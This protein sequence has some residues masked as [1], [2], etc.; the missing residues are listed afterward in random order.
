M[1]GYREEGEVFAIK[2]SDGERTYL[3]MPQQVV[4][5]TGMAMPPMDHRTSKA[6]FQHGSSFVGF[7]LNP[8]PI[9]IMIHMRGCHRLGLWDLR[10][11]FINRINPLVG[12]L[13]F[14]V[15]YRNGDI[16][17]L[18][19]VV[20]D[21]GFNVGTNQ[22][23]EPAVQRFGARFIAYDPVWFQWPERTETSALTLVDEL[24]FPI[25][26]PIIF[27]ASAIDD[28]LTIVTTGNWL[29]YP[30]IVLTGPMASPRIVN[31]T[32][33]EELHLEYNISTTETVVITTSF[34]NKTVENTEG[35]NLLGYLSSDSDLA[36]FHLDP[37]PIA[38]DGVNDLRVYANGCTLSSAF[39]VRWFDRFLGL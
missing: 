7:S 2:S 17:E 18:H 19:D 33:E 4:E 29:T 1:P 10:R 6:P 16:F 25:E 13:R 27:G 24:I 36:T 37:D 9:Q 14:R 12:S 30:T 35:D 23:P 22:Q 5:V 26:F 39:Y 31:E 21:A 34:G 11:Q 3:E 20:Y 15:S 28:V 38:E 32:T 8:R